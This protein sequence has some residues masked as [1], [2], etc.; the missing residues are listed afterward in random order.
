MAAVQRA[1]GTALL[2]DAEH[3]FDA[4]YSK[5]LSTAVTHRLLVTAPLQHLAAEP[6]ATCHCNEEPS[7]SL[8]L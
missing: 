5:V 4:Q 1:G 2:I 6:V 3:A 8:T 7:A